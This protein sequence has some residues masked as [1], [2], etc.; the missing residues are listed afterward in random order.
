MILRRVASFL[1][2]LS[3]SGLAVLR[4]TTAEEVIAR[5]RAFVGKE[6]AFS[7]L[8]SVHYIGNVTEGSRIY[9]IEIV[10]QKPYFQRI[11]MKFP[12]E[13]KDPGHTEVIGLDDSEAW[14]RREMADGR[15][16]MTLLDPAQ[17]KRFRANVWENLNFYRGIEKAGGKVQYQGTATIG[18]KL[19]DKLLYTHPDDITFTRYFDTTTGQIMQTELDNGT[20]LREE[21]EIVVDNV[22][23]PKKLVS[24]QGD[25]TVVINLDE[26]RVNETFPRI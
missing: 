11:T 15:W 16:D 13:D 26:I 24:T 14:Q 5:A 17:I 6:E 8:K 23:F 7:G 1:L 19:C 4:A 2:L 20:Q 18:G 22:R 21:G 3:V 12:K 10:F 25:K 9:T